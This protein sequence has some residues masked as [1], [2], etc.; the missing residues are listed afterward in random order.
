MLGDSYSLKYCIVPGHRSSAMAKAKSPPVNISNPSSSC[1]LPPAEQKCG[2]TS[3]GTFP[4]LLSSLS[5]LTLP[6]VACL[7]CVLRPTNPNQ[8]KKLKPTVPVSVIFFWRASCSGSISLRLW[9]GPMLSLSLCSAF[10]AS[11]AKSSNPPVRSLPLFYLIGTGSLAKSSVSRLYQNLFSNTSPSK[12]TFSEKSNRMA[13]DLGS[14]F[15]MSKWETEK[16]I[17]DDRRR[18]WSDGRMYTSISGGACSR[19]E[20]QKCGICQVRLGWAKIRDIRNRYCIDTR[21]VRYQ[22]YW[23]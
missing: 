7:A 18:T 1:L 8:V 2:R 16:D 22:Y 13:T 21:I 3:Q 17:K 14:T 11:H 10:Q 6:A 23:F 5:V 9:N 19:T 15:A 12:Y 4:R 20:G